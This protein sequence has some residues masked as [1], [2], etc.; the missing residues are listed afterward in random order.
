[1][2]A[3]ETSAQRSRAAVPHHHGRSGAE[4]HP[5]LRPH[6]RL[7][8]RDRLRHP[9]RW[10]HRLF[11]R[12]DHPVLRS[13][14]GK[15]HGLGADAGGNARKRM[16]RALREFRIR[17]VATNLTFLE[18]D[19]R[20]PEIPR[21]HLHDPVHRHDAGAVR[22]GQAPGPRTKLLT[23]IADV[24]VNGHPETKGRPAAGRCGCAAGAVSAPVATE[25]AAPG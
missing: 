24:T 10:R 7:S 15:G 2:P 11:R 16:D 20:P 1:V 12:G 9:P 8:R 14:S 4:L 18:N 22:A 5:R 17:G 3:Q 23:Y 25:R 13:A 21:Q 19:H 6:H